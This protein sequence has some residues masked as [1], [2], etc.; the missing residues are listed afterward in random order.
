[1]SST[2]S[3]TKKVLRLKYATGAR[4]LLSHNI[5][6]LNSSSRCHL[7]RRFHFFNSTIFKRGYQSSR[8]KKKYTFT[9]QHPRY[10]FPLLRIFN[11]DAVVAAAAFAVAAFV[12]VVGTEMESEEIRSNAALGRVV[13]TQGLVAENGAEAAARN[14]GEDKAVHMLE[15]L[16]AGQAAHK[17]EVG[18]AAYNSDAEHNS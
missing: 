2:T 18:Q 16:E 5:V 1:M 10:K 12:A 15:T 14:L 11:T 3:T 6:R 17:L 4:H 13:N 8:T 9:I 7:C